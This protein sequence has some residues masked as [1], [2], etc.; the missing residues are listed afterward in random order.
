METNPLGDLINHQSQ[1]ISWA[2]AAAGVL[3]VLFLLPRWF[4]RRRRKKRARSVASA[5]IHLAELGSTGPS[6][7]GPQLSY[8]GVPV[9]LALL[10]IAPAGREGQRVADSQ[11]GDVLDRAVPGLGKLMRLQPPVIRHWPGQLSSDGFG[12]AFFRE[13]GL[14]HE[15]LGTP[16][17][18]VVG[19]IQTGDQRFFV[20]LLLRSSRANNLKQ[21]SIA[22]ETQ[23]TEAL[24]VSGV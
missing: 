20:G 9:H 18:N 3:F 1:L 12:R 13:C 16:W 17:S 23:W 11:V 7:T 8:L 14:P 10:V 15:G 19:P 6:D 22:K 2:I 21:L 5:P 4:A 24:R